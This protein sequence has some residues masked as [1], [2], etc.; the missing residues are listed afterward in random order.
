LIASPLMI[1]LWVVREPFVRAIFGDQWMPVSVVI[2]WL[3][4]VGL[5]QSLLSP[6]GLLYMVTG[7]TDVMMRVGTVVSVVIF[8][9]MLIGLGWG[10]V[11]VAIGYAIANALILLPCLVIPFA[12]VGLSFREF[13]R[14]VS[15]PFAI[16]SIMGLIVWTVLGVWGVNS[17]NAALQ[18]S[19]L[20]VLGVTLFIS[21]A[22]MFIK[23]TVKQV[24]DILAKAWSD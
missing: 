20:V 24:T 11:G 18:L 13:L 8:L 3:A 10:Y 1:G 2:A 22:L 4:P 7:R 21:M 6:V 12:L 16:S 15:A 19:V 17:T 9:A 23:P 5:A 14:A